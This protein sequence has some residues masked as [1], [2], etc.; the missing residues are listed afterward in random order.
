MSHRA[1][2][3]Q[4]R[5]DYERD[6]PPTV[7]APDEVDALHPE[8][9]YI[10]KRTKGALL[11]PVPVQHLQPGMW[12]REQGTELP[13]QRV[14]HSSTLDTDR[15]EDGPVYIAQFGRHT[16]PHRGEDTIFHVLAR[17]T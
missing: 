10:K 12:A 4:W 11:T 3:P 5:R 13:F 7:A 17:R 2:G 6:L 9:G 16:Y 1:L 15:P 8:N 14:S